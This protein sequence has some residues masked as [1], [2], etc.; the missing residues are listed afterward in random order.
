MI[1][2]LIKNESTG[3]SAWFGFPLYFGKL[4]K[5]GHSGD[6]NDMVHVQEVEG[7]NLFGPGYYTLYELEAL[8]NIA[9]RMEQ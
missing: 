7:T 4:S 6:Y 5:I 9:K 8:N 2:A 3:K 1:H